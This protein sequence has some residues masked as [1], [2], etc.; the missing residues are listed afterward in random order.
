[1]NLD[2]LT[3]DGCLRSALAMPEIAADASRCRSQLVLQVCELD[4]A[5][6]GNTG[7]V[8]STVLWPGIAEGRQIFLRASASIWE[9]VF[10]RVPPVGYQSIGAL[11]RQCP[12]FILQ[13]CELETA[14][15]LPFME[16]L[17]E[18]MRTALHPAQPDTQDA[19]G[20]AR[21]FD[22]L[23]N[24]RGSYLAIG[25]SGPDW[26]YAEHAGLDTGP[27]L[28]MLHTAGADS[29]QWHGL[30]S[31]TAMQQAWNMHAFD[32]PGHGRSPLPAGEANWNWRLT[33]E[34][35]L[36]WVIGYMDAAGLER[37][38]LTGCSMG[39]AISLALLARFPHRFAGAL[40]LETPYRSPGRRSPY[41]NDPAVDSG[42]LGA[43]WVGSLLSPS[44]PKAGRDFATW[45]YSQAAP[46]VYDG[47]LGY[48]SD[49]FDA[50]QHTAKIDAKRT[51][52]W[53][54]TGDYDYSATPDDTRKVVDEIPGA[55]FIPL[56]GFGHF[57]MVENPKGLLRHLEAPLRQLSSRLKTAHQAERETAQD[58]EIRPVN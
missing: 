18:G 3:L 34:R 4:A 14:Q 56:P 28:L 31:E 54:L 38:V 16:R 27:T 26:V 8:E 6:G 44:S 22:G 45:I 19:S 47:D 57:P 35:Y 48:Y 55:Q 10:Q 32:L 25:A 24:V 15:A 23:G 50:H 42:R 7:N 37:V 49:D 11:R 36:Q 53:F 12:G 20:A 51:P 5:N 9:R 43:A 21:Q 17:I 40:L 2:L 41:L 29:R 33:E 30:M 13:G 39:A 58:Q 1:V 52:I 46:S